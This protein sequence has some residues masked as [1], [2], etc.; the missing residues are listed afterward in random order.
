MADLERAALFKLLFYLGLRWRAE[1][2]SRGPKHVEKNGR[3]TWLEIGSTN[4]GAPVMKPVHK[5][6]VSALDFIPFDKPVSHYRRA[7]NNAREAIGRPELRPHELRHSLASEVLSRTGGTL[8]DVCAALHHQSVQ[9]VKRYAYLYPECMKQITMGA[10]SV[11]QKITH[12]SKNR[13]PKIAKKHTLSF[14]CGANLVGRV[15]LEPTTKG[16]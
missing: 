8:N 9:A 4:N 11:V 12:R 3:D 5:D 1:L 15:G 7:W 2:L 10:G 16:L 14:F 6:E 13:Q